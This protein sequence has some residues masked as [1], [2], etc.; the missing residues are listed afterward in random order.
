MNEMVFVEKELKEN[1]FLRMHYSKV[2]KEAD[3]KITQKT[4]MNHKFKTL[5]QYK[6]IVPYE[7]FQKVLREFIF[8]ENVD[9]KD[10]IDFVESRINGK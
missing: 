2:V 1:A 5:F 9:K 6:L 8:K 3:I 4:C 10:I 7:L